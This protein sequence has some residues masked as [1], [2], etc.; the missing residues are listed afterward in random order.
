MSADGI[1][2]ESQSGLTLLKQH[3][4][5][6][7]ELLQI[8]LA[9]YPEVLAG[10]TTSGDGE[11]RLLLVRRE[12]GVPSEQDGAGHFSLDHLFLDADGV[13]VLVEVKRS[14]DTRI[15]REVVGQ[16][17]DYAANAVKYWP[18]ELLQQSLEQTASAAG[19]PVEELIRELQS[20]LDPAEFWKS[21]ETNL[22]S[23]RIRMVFVADALPVE[24]VRV[25][26]FLNEQMSPAEVLGV[27][28]LQYVGGG[29][30]AYVPRV[31]GRT[32]NA[33]SVKREAGRYWSEDTFMQ[34][35]EGRCTPAE[36]TIIRR[37][38]EDV[39]ARG[40]KLSWGKGFTPGVAGWYLLNDQ[41]TPVWVLN[42]N[43]EN[44]NTRAY[45][46]FYLADVLPRAGMDRVDSM[47]SRLATI[48]ALEPK[49]AEA[50]AGGWRKYPTL[51]IAD[52][53]D[54]PQQAQILFDSITELLKTG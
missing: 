14:A 2:L 24:L 16:M 49:I 9:R 30:V 54:D 22:K 8:A 42:A 10:P 15:R 38:F 40:H 29:Q 50:R 43:N 44:P 5:D 1:F 51:Y 41:P 47:A 20:D 33:V 18:L 23:G 4:Y 7:E 48:P 32:S 45:L 37:L 17:L 21:V 35:A 25:I 36:V 12:L 31:V 34:A 46:M 26:E 39:Q 52:V 53:A 3:A 13:P 19:K 28:L 27:E 6:S 11:A